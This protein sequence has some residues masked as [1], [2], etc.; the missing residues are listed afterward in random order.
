MIFTTIITIYER[1]DNFQVSSIMIR[2]GDGYYGKLEI[3]FITG[4]LNSRKYVETIDEQID[5][6]ATRIAGNKYNF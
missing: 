5:T 2:G 1:S 6:Y 4:K 3:K